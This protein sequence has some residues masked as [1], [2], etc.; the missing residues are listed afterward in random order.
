ME[1]DYD[2]YYD[3]KVSRPFARSKMGFALGALIAFIGFFD[4]I[5]TVLDLYITQYNMGNSQ[6]NAGLV[7]TWDE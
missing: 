2:E 5:L 4:I 7:M 6:N 1:H 3:T